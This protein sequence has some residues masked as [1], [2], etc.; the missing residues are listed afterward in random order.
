MLS[1]QGEEMKGKGTPHSKE[2]DQPSPGGSN[3][4]LTDRYETCW[5]EIAE[6]EITSIQPCPIIPDYKEPTASTLPIVVQTPAA[7]FCI[8]GWHFI[9]QAKAA[10]R[11]TIRCHISHIAQH[12]DTELAIRKSA[13]RVMPQGGKCS[14]AELV[15]NTH[16]LYQALF[17]T[18]DDL[19]LFSHGGDRRGVSFTSSQENNIRLV[20][21][22]RLG[23]SQTTINKYLQHGD[24]LNDA[25]LGALIDAGAPK[26]FFEAF[27]TQKQ[28][29]VAALNAE[30][31]DDTAIVEAI[32]KQMLEWL[33]EFLQPVPPNVPSPVSIQ[34]PQ[35]TQSPGSVQNTPSENRRPTP[36]QR[37]PHASSG[38]GGSP[39]SDPTP[40]NPEGVATELKRI[41]QALI[42]IADDRQRPIP[43]QFEKV[44]NLILELT[45]LLPRLAHMGAREDGGKG[46][47]V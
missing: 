7:S 36:T 20:L 31:K 8:D 18:L 17:D 21:A 30:Q 39:A 45:T 4:P 2:Q 1:P 16:H 27:Q 38:T 13:I 43:R 22:I 23:K 46:G 5:E 15:R 3:E 26:V 37:V 32:S 14:H 25:A 40:A 19:V 10:D 34:E 29:E 28:V 11:S 47:K 6:L 41:C 24:S 35:T 42:E 44:R 9:E 33:S 12:S